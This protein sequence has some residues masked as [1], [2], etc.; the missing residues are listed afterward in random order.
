VHAPK[1]AYRRET[2]ARTRVSIER[3][4]PEQLVMQLTAF[5]EPVSSSCNMPRKVSAMQWH[6]EVMLFDYDAEGTTLSK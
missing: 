3:T 5:C 2:H 4:S 1:V 6:E